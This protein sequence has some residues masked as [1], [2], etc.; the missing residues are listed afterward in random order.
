MSKID[1]PHKPKKGDRKLA[2]GG[3]IEAGRVAIVGERGCEIV[4]TSARA[5]ILEVRRGN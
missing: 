1:K 4:M 2:N 3:T 5:P